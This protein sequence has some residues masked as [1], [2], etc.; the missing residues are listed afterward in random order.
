MS[1]GDVHDTLNELERKL[2][3]LQD[4]LSGSGGQ[5]PSPTG[6]PPMPPY[7]PPEAHTPPP[8][9]PPPAVPPPAGGLQ[10]QLEELLRFRDQLAEAAKGLVEDYSRV[11]EQITRATGAS[12]APPPPTPASGHVTFPVPPPAAP[13][14]ESTLYNG[15]VA[16]D[17]GPFADIATLAG[18]ED[19]LRHVPHAEDVYV[20]SFEAHRALLELR[21]AAEV[22]LVFELR[23]ASDQAFDVD[24]ADPG[25]L[26]LTMHSANLPFPM[27]PANEREAP[28]V[29]PAN[30]G[31]TD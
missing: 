25:R 24:H 16:V 8:P 12:P 3:E 28:P 6:P 10:D 11:L 5:P 30:G 22:P 17:A 4:E 19:A 9:P 15:H 20:R 26:A 14:T 27:R 21:L 7:R 2:R 23:R 31:E 1:G 29:P 13:S 18:F